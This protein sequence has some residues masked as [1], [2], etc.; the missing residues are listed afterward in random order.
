MCYYSQGQVFECFAVN[1]LYHLQC[2]DRWLIVAALLNSEHHST[3]LT[4]TMLAP[5]HKTIYPLPIQILQLQRYN[6]SEF[7]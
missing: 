3:K 7:E 2:K 4:R 6:G 1:N 5:R